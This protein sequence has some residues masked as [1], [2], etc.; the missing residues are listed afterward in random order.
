MILQWILFLGTAIITYIGIALFAQLSGGNSATSWQA[1]FSGIRLIP[2]IIGTVANMFFAL[3]IYYGF[4]ITRYAI[5]I[6]IAIGS[7]TSFAYSIVVFGTKVTV[8]KILG[9]I[10]TIAGIVL[11]EL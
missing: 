7:I 8:I 2:L 4:T 10:L 9:I 6:T 1:F 5:P 11:L 3:A